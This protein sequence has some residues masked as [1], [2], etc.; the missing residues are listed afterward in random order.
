MEG[1]RVI[2][3]IEAANAGFT[4]LNLPL[5][6]YNDTRK[7][8]K[9]KQW[10]PDRH[11]LLGNHEDRITRATEEDA[12][13]DGLLTLDSLIYSDLGWVVHPYLKPVELEGVYYA[14]YFANP[15]TGRPY[16]GTALTRLKTLGHSFTMGHQQTL[17]IAIRPV[18][19][20]LQHGL[21]AGACYL[22]DEEYKGY[23]GNAH[24]RGIVICHEVREGHYDPM[25]VSLDYLCRRYEGVDLGEFMQ[26]KYGRAA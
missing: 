8:Y 19:G 25:V 23:Q 5:L 15:F 4:E 17:D 22:H 12:Q 1:R 2:A 20:K 3:D 7:A 11:I 26:K 9:E 13:L 16:G 24:W 14:H 18:A 6:R 21:I 10:W